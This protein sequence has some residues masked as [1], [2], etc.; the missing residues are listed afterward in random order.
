[1]PRWYCVVETF[2]LSRRNKMEFELKKGI[3]F[4]LH[5]IKIVRKP[6][7]VVIDDRIQSYLFENLGSNLTK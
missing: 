2:F 1:M 5:E 6:H 3:A 4:G 7:R